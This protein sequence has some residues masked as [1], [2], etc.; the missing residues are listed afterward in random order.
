MLKKRIVFYGIPFC[1]LLLTAIF[2]MTYFVQGE[3]MTVPEV[4]HFPQHPDMQTGKHPPAEMKIMTLNIAHGRKDGFSQILQD[5]AGIRSH[6]DDIVKTVKK[7]SPFL[8]ALQEADGPSL[9]SGN[10]DHVA[11]IAE[12]AGFPYAIRGEHVRGMGLSYGTALLSRIFPEKPVSLTF[13]PSPPTFSKG[14]VSAVFRWPGNP[15]MKIRAVS[16]HLDFSR[17]S[18]RTRQIH[19]MANFVS[20]EELPFVIM[21][22]FNCGWDKGRSELAMMAGTIKGKTYLPEAD[23]LNTFYGK[24]LDWIVLSPH[25]EFGDYRVLPDILSDHSAVLSFIRESAS[26]IRFQSLW[27]NRICRF[28]GHHIRKISS[29]L[30]EAL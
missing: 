4:L 23:N 10:F 7:E 29:P 18:V 12:K 2:A 19:K 9:W 11:Y 21:G 6:L 16:V 27:Q 1:L 24:R 13:S 30:Y 5:S 25:F 20:A 22:D 15:D 14:F 8:L 28:Q 26:G 17:K 3:T